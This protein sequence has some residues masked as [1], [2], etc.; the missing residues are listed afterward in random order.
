MEKRPDIARD[1]LCLIGNDYRVVEV[2]SQVRAITPVQWR[3]RCI[4]QVRRM[5]ELD[6]QAKRLEFK[7]PDPSKSQAG[8]YISVIE[9]LHTSIIPE[10]TYGGGDGETGQSP[11]LEGQFTR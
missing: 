7:S 4:S 10:H 5:R 9:V 3:A 11:E 1:G 6:V 2:R 8:A